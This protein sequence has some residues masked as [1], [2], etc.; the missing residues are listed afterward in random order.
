MGPGLETDMVT[1]E[2]FAMAQLDRDARQ[3]ERLAQREFR[4]QKLLE[5]LSGQ[6][7]EVLRAM[8]ARLASR[9]NELIA[10][11]PE[12]RVLKEML[13]GF[14]VQLLAGERIAQEALR[15]LFPREDLTTL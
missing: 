5:D 11:D 8:A 2:P 9:I 13:E 15:P 1:G 12:A 10:G 3:Q 14:E 6:G 7:G 4:H